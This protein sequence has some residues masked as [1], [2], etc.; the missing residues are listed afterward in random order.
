[1]RKLLALVAI[2]SSVLVAFILIRAREPQSDAAIGSPART[3]ST[4]G[5]EAGSELHEGPTRA[6]EEPQPALVARPA[7]AAATTPPAVEELEL[8]YPEI[9][10][11]LDYVEGNFARESRDPQWSSAMEA[12]ILDEIARKALGL[13][14]THLEVDCHA[15]LCR[16]QMVFPQELA[17]R[18]GGVVPKGT[19]WTGDQPI[20]FF[21]DALDF[22]IREGHAFAGL[23]TYGTPFLVGYVSRQTEAPDR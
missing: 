8:R 21:L 5:R 10:G 16:L 6:A 20:S 3:D 1:M 18:R 2:L 19:P 11:A 7:A 15:T 12:H 14:I 23:D 9:R 13:E 22:E 4:V 17:R